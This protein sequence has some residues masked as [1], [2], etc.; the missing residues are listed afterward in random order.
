LCPQ[1]RW[2]RKKQPTDE[3]LNA[4][5]TMTFEQRRSRATDVTSRRGFTTVELIVVIV[6]VGIMVAIALPRTTAA[7]QQLTIDAAVHQLHNDLSLARVE[8]VKRNTQVRVARVGTT[9]YTISYGSPVTILS[10]RALP[11]GVQFGLTSPDT[12]KFAAFGP[13]PTGAKTYLMT[14]GS[15]TKTVRVNAAGM[16]ASQ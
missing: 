4:V 3:Q 6:L 2:G 14:Y 8:A 12:I 15:K 1:I 10:T 5:M 11:E 9:G 16:V 7:R 13:S